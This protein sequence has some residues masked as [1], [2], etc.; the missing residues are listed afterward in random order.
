MVNIM[1]FPIACPTIL[2]SLTVFLKDTLKTP[3]TLNTNITH[4]TPATSNT[5]THHLTGMEAVLSHPLTT[6]KPPSLINP[7][8]NRLYFQ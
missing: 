3:I 7:I 5:Q 4:I 6:L 2:T 1:E 8:T